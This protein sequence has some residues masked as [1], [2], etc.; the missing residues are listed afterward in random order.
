MEIGVG[1]GANFSYYGTIKRLTLIEPDVID[2]HDLNKKLEHVKAENILLIE[3]PIEE[4][5]LTPSS[6]DAIVATLIFC[7]VTDPEQLLNVVH[8]T[9]K[10]GGKF[11]FLEHIRA[12]SFLQRTFQYIVNPFWHAISGGCQCTRATDVQL[13]SD[14]RF[15]VVS[16]DFFRT[17]AGF[18]WVKDHVIGVL[19]KI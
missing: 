14:P 4:M 11:F 1:F 12:K 10:S 7:S 17:K 8:Q 19:E 5:A 2:A 3:K 16:S 6:A 9:L 13:L 15:A 18:P